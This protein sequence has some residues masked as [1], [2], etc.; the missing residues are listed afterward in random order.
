[1]ADITYDLGLL[2]GSRA[3]W[4]RSQGLRTVYR[5]I[6]RDILS[7]VGEGDVLDIGSGAGFLKID[8]PWVTTS[9]VVKTP[10]VDLAVSA[11][12]IGATGRCW[13]GI[14]AMDVLHH[15]RE[16]FRFLE[17]AA[18]SL[19]PGGRIALAEPAATP[20]GRFFYRLFHHE[21]CRPGRLSEPWLF[22]ADSADGDF[23]NMGMG[24]ALFDRDR[25]ATED[26]LA[27]LNLSLVSV[28]YRDLFAYPA[29][30]GLSRKQML[31]DGLYP[32]LLRAE[33]AMPQWLLR[34]LG[35]RMIVVLERVQE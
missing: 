11:Y 26:R 30:G 25:A 23:A 14:V 27:G 4:E 21:P 31:P 7:A 16:P 29:T 24:W 18:G 17:S 20:M 32:G 3:K 9:D 2:E 22:E 8:H 6:F 5:S 28:R 15:L 34:I 13:S 35:L 1:M 33:G 10:Y 12:E 19:E